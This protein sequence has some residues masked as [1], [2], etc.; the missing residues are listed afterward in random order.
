MSLQGALILGPKQMGS[1]KECSA[2]RAG[3]AAGKQ[4]ESSYQCQC[5]FSSRSCLSNKGLLCVC[6]SCVYLCLCICVLVVQK[7][8]SE[9]FLSSNLET[10]PLDGAHC[11]TVL[12]GH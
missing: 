6:V 7:S 4:Q 2:L 8:I 10:R 5:Y 1:G 12:A 9:I 11:V 3:E